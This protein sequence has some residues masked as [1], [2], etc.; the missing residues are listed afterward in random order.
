MVVS[1]NVSFHTGEAYSYEY[2]IIR[3]D[4]K[5]RYVK[6]IERALPDDNGNLQNSYG[7]L[8]DLT[9]FKQAMKALQQS[10]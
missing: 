5:I 1:A 7:V 2:R 4:G 6:E 9:E 3:P 8:Q 10:E